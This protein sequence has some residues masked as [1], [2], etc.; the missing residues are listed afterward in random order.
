MNRNGEY[1]RKLDEARALDP[2]GESDARVQQARRSVAGQVA[3]DAA[4]DRKR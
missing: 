4:F 1:E 2:A 3:P